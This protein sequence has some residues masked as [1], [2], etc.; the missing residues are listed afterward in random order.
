MEVPDVAKADVFLGHLREWEDRNAMP[1]LVMMNL[2]SDHTEGISP[3]WCTPKACVA[4]NDLALGKIVDGL[5][6]SRFENRHRLPEP[7]VRKDDDEHPVR[8]HGTRDPRLGPNADRAGV[9]PSRASP[10]TLWKTGEQLR[11]L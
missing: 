5:S 6:H 3:G 7:A 11:G 9:A 2:P 10:P 1:N 4:D 8:Q